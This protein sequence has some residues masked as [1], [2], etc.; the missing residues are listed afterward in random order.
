MKA[1]HP[2]ANRNDLMADKEGW[3]LVLLARGL[4]TRQIAETMGISTHYV[5]YLSTLLMARFGVNTRA[6]VV[7]RAILEG[8]ISADGQLLRTLRSNN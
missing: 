7:S 2:L 5:Y 3:M 1:K 8:I 4:K 6:A